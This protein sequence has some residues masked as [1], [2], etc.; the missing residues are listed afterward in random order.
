M[1]DQTDMEL[2]VEDELEGDEEEVAEEKAPDLKDVIDALHNKSDS[3][4]KLTASWVRGQLRKG[5]AHLKEAFS[6]DS[7]RRW[8]I[9]VDVDDAATAVAEAWDNRR[10]RGAASADASED[11]GMDTEDGDMEEG[12]EE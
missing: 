8:V 10:K 4:D 3:Y 7:N 9:D 2:E 1:S 5:N 6:Q 11:E 12:D